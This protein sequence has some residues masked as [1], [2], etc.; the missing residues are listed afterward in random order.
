MRDILFVLLI[1]FIGWRMFSG[2][3]YVMK[4]SWRRVKYHWAHTLEH[5]GEWGILL[6]TTILGAIIVIAILTV[7]LKDLL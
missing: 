2:Q 1:L 3:R 4:K 5:L 6:G 7:Y